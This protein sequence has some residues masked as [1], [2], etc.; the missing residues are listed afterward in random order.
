MRHPYL[1]LL[2]SFPITINTTFHILYNAEVRQNYANQLQRALCLIGAGKK[3]ANKRVCTTF[4]IFFLYFIVYV[5]L[6]IS[7][8][9]SSS[10]FISR[11]L[12]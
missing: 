12:L 6:F 10:L 3:Y 2:S 9:T 8:T 4:S 5:K 7:K 1:D 11:E